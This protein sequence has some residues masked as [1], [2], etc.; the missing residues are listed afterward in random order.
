MGI[1]VYLC[2]LIITTKIVTQYTQ[3]SQS[4]FAFHLLQGKSLINVEVAADINSMSLSVTVKQGRIESIKKH[5]SNFTN[6]FR[7]LKV[8]TAWMNSQ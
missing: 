1:N 6:L 2:V 7:D 8:F 5:E 3:P 4:M